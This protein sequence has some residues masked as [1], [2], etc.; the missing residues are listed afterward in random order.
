MSP[1]VKQIVTS[2]LTPLTTQKIQTRNLFYLH[3]AA[4]LF[5][6]CRWPWL[7]LK[8]LS[9]FWVIAYIS[10]QRNQTEGKYLYKWQAALA[11]APAQVWGWGLEHGCRWWSLGCRCCL[12]P[13]CHKYPRLSSCTG[14]PLL[15]TQGGARFAALF[16]SCFGGNYFLSALHH[17][18]ALLEVIKGHVPLPADLLYFINTIQVYLERTSSA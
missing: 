8:T 14:P 5:L 10:L 1:W 3:R 6:G 11:Q 15:L 7:Y 9:E 4:A 13:P 18:E 16:W 12:H 17:C 2:E